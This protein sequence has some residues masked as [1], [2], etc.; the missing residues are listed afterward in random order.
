MLLRWLLQIVTLVCDTGLAM[1]PWDPQIYLAALK[2]EDSLQLY[3]I[4]QS[5][6]NEERR[7]SHLTLERLK[8]HS[9]DDGADLRERAMEHGHRLWHTAAGTALTG[10]LVAV[11]LMGLWRHLR[12][13]LSQHEELGG[14][15]QGT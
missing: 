14:K 9:E 2:G 5:L 8:Q 7:G 3:R 12:H 10:K 13:L 4:C 11:G 6:M 15:M 1:T